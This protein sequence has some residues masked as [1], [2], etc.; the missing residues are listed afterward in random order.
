MVFKHQLTPLTKGGAITKHKGKGSQ[1][2]AMP[3]RGQISQLAKPANQNINNYAKATPMA[4]PQPDAAT[5]GM[6]LGSGSWAGN[7]M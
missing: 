5:T 2:A 3:D 7:G 4:Q 1:A 6:G